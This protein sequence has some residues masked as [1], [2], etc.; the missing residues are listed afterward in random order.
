M[1]A[2]V[3]FTAFDP[4]L[5]ATT[6]PTMIAD[7]I[8]ERIGFDGALMSDDLSMGALSGT[9]RERTRAALA[10]GC[11]LVLHCNGELAEMEDVATDAPALA[12]EAARRCAAALAMRR[13]GDAIEIEGARQRFAQILADDG[14]VTVR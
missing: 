4:K 10:A 14:R 8:R 12:G 6:S 9:L 1:T 5:P 11:D 2:H 3:V 7:V 13:A